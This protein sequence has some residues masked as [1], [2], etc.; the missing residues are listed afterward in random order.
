MKQR[1]IP[2]QS[3]GL[4]GPSNRYK[5]EKGE[6]SL[7]GP[8]YATLNYYEIYCLSGNLFDDIERFETLEEAETRIREL[9][10]D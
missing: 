7:V 5:T 4:A 1:T 10:D 6:I 2:S 9:L 3:P 8:C